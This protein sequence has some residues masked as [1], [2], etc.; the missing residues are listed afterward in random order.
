[1]TTYVGIDLGTTN[2]AIVSYDGENLKLYKS[3]DFQAPVTPSVIYFAKHGGRQYG[4]RAYSQAA[5]NPDNVAKEFKRMIG[6]STPVI[7]KGANLRLTPEECSADI[8][9][10]LWGYLPDA[11]R[12]EQAGGTVITTPAAFNQMQKDA[13]LAAAETAGLGKVALMQEPVAAVMSVMKVRKSDGVFLIYDLGGGTLDI[14]LAQSVSGR[15]SLL[16]HGGIAMCGGSDFDRALMDNLVKPWLMENF[17]L[18]ENLT[19]EPKYNQ[20]LRRARYAAEQ[21]KIELS[22]RPEA[23]IQLDDSALQTKDLDGNDIYLTI[24]LTQKQFDA[25]IEPKLNESIQAA[26]EVLEKA[27][28]APQDVERVVF[29]G[30]P[31]NYK[32]I[33]EKVSFELGIPGSM[34]VDPMT[35]VAE[36]AAVFAE[37]IDWSSASRGR[38]T[39]RGSVSV[40]GKL[41][42]SFN[43]Q[44]RTPDTKAK[45][46]VQAKG[47]QSGHTFQID[48][49][50]S[51]WSS[52]RLELKDGASMT[53]PLSKSGDNRFKVFAFDSSGG[54]VSIENAQIVITRTTATI[55][56]IPASHSIGVSA[57]ELSGRVTLDYLVKKGDTL[58]KKGRKTWRSEES[59][60]AG[61]S[62]AIVIKLWEG[63]IET[64]YT[65]NRPIGEFKITGSDFEKGVI[66]AKAELICDYE[67]NDAGHISMTVTVPSVSG[68]FSPGHNFY[69]RQGGQIDYTQA[70]KLIEDEREKVSSHLDTVADSVSDP[71]L[72][73]ARRLVD[74]SEP[75]PADDPDGTASKQ[76]MD[77][78]LEAK[79]L[80]SKVRQD[81]LG[82]LRTLEL[83]QQQEFFEKHMRKIANPT[84]A[85]AFD[86]L[87]RTA[88]R[89]IDQNTGDFENLLSQIT[90]LIFQILWRQEWFV[91]DMFKRFASEEHLF[92][93]KTKFRELVALGAAAVQKGD[94]GQLR[95]VLGALQS[96]RIASAGMSDPLELV[97]ILK[98]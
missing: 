22:Q 21:A 81:N 25:L 96:I 36:G 12:Q 65:D 10:V 71:R 43:Y 90:D 13:T 94:I 53:V 68:S 83:E 56:A 35:A 59:L 3:P 97:N 86:T 54:P 31:T 55:D 61:G 85:N 92:T 14:A 93:D 84:E 41:N 2:S 69:S 40:G 7:V 52:G 37:S 51:G 23:L 78:L 44:S 75:S 11:V 76:K 6:T 57:K 34:D 42:V 60:K 87:C 19:A 77:N 95:Q 82:E 18:P 67:V 16:E 70:A 24:P 45:L 49:V 20:L 26:R 79:R 50:D 48:S 39:T 63:D 64:P 29:V 38:K 17:N 4:A 62:G 58:P 80:I 66:H 98:G 46:A 88:R 47:V 33:R 8:L 89:A 27:G 72:Q 28:H 9:R 5:L 32:A 73:Q 91:V 1:M 30:G 74:E 15:V